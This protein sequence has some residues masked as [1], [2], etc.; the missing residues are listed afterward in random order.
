MTHPSMIA[1]RPSPEFRTSR[2]QL[3]VAKDS[4]SAHPTDAILCDNTH[5]VR[6]QAT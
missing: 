4:K 3:K 5:A 1:L 6:A 2:A